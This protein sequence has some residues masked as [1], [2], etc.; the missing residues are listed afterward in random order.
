MTTRARWIPVL[1]AAIALLL[2]LAPTAVAGKKKGKRQQAKKRENSPLVIGHRGASGYLPEHTIEAYRL[3]IRLGADYI[4][5]DLVST[6]DG[7]LIARHEPILGVVGDAVGDSTDV[8][9]R[10]EF[11]SKR[12]PVV[13]IDGVNYNGWVASDFT[14]AEIKQLR[15]VQTR[16]GRSTEFNGRFQIPT[17][18]EVINLA[19]RESKRSGR[20]I[21]IYPE[22]K[23]PT[24]HRDEAHLPLEEK[25]VKTLKRNGL[26]R[27]N[28]PVFIQSF[29][30]ANL[31]QLNRMTKVR[32]V[33]LVDAYDTDATS[34]VPIFTEPPYQRPWDWE[35]SGR[36]D[37]YSYFT[38]DAG[39]AEI[40]TYADGIGPWKPYI[41]PM[42]P[43]NTEVFDPTDLVQ[44]A[45]AHGLLIHTWTFR[46]D[47]F[48]SEYGNPIAEMRKFFELGVDGVFTDFPDSGVIAREFFRNG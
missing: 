16:D 37:L 7:V 3:A 22:T 18:Q 5:P 46:D 15:A 35:V 19:R 36:S 25:L 31:K 9:S 21:G 12:R 28:A 13:T 17:L 38:T 47:S 24:W 1:L 30:Q 29:E 2:A 11:A 23:H 10:P 27:R 20:R 33:Q 14:L 44:R 45:H 6:K 26:N 34:G 32:L 40:K 41:V 4:E 8:E 42:L 39:L 43:N 48:P